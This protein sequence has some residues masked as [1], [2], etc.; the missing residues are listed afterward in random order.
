MKVTGED[1]TAWP[2]LEVGGRILW[3]QGAEL[4]P[5]PAIRITAEPTSS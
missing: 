4:E 2:V 3:M 1:R 5:D